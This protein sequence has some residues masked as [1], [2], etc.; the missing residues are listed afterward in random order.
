MLGSG[1][2]MVRES[3]V[4]A[5]FTDALGAQKG[6]LAVGKLCRGSYNV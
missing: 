4:L 2:R 1:K 5:T 3:V 6:T